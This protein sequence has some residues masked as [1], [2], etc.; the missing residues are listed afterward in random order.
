MPT[1]SVTPT[2]FNAADYLVARHLRDG[3]GARTAV[4]AQSRPLSL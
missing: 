1:D 2:T 3:R 4:V